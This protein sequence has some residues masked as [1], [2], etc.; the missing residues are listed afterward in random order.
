MIAVLLCIAFSGMSEF[1]CSSESLIPF[2]KAISRAPAFVL[3]GALVPYI[4]TRVKMNVFYIVAGSIVLLILYNLIFPHG[5]I[6]WILSV[7]VIAL[8]CVLIEKVSFLKEVAAFMG[9]MSL[10]SYLWNV[11]LG[12]ILNHVSWKLGGYDF[13]YGHYL[14]YATVLIVGIALAYLCYLID[15]RAIEQVNKRIFCNV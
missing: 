8:S 7:P 11:H 14:E 15:K 5:N 6:L 12:A 9:F 2:S 4:K 3:G 13:S 1:T 10:E